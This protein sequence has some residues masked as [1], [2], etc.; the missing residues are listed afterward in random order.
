MLPGWSARSDDR[1]PRARVRGFGGHAMRGCGLPHRSRSDPARRV[2]L[3]RSVAQ[4]SPVLSLCRPG[5]AD[6]SR[7]EQS[8]PSCWSIF[9]G[10]TG[11]SPNEPSVMGFRSTTTVRRS[12]GPGAAGESRRCAAMSITCWQCCRSNSITSRRQG[13]PTHLCGAPVLRRGRR[14]RLDWTL[15]LI[16]RFGVARQ[17][18]QQLVA[19]LP[20]SRDHEVH[21]NWPLM[22]ESIRRLHRRHPEHVFLVASYR[23]RQCLWCRDQLRRVDAAL[24]IEFYVDRTSEVIEAARL[25]DDGQRQCQPGVDGPPDAGGCRLSRRP[26]PCIRL[27]KRWCGWTVSRLPI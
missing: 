14:S 13:I 4:T 10:S 5:R 9:P 27:R 11:T 21:R 8:M 2:G 15:D 18:G 19:V 6:V 16:G 22:L 12:F 1:I 7:A 17:S 24:P 23:D 3:A 26:T 20:G 25:C